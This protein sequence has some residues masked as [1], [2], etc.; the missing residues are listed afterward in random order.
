MGAKASLLSQQAGPKR[1]RRFLSVVQTERS[2]EFLRRTLQ[3][4]FVFRWAKQGSLEAS[5]ARLHM[6]SIIIALHLLV[7]RFTKQSF[8]WQFISAV[9]PLSTRKIHPCTRG[10][11][12]LVSQSDGASNFKLLQVELNCLSF[13][14]GFVS[15]TG[16][17]NTR[18]WMPW[19]NSRLQLKIKQL[20]LRSWQSWLAETRKEVST[21]STSAAPTFNRR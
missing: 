2:G 21:S 19:K 5:P 3:A 20:V 12:W 8:F 11:S 13:S 6:A 7:R 14:Q 9:N 4:L 1:K 10:Q 15:P 18:N 16:N 17:S